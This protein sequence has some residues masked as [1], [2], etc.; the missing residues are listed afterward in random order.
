MPGQ[1]LGCEDSDLHPRRHPS[2]ARRTTRKAQA[3]GMSRSEFFTRAVARYL[4]ELDAE[5]ITEQIDL[6]RPPALT[7]KTIPV[8]T[9][10]PA[11]G[12]S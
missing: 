5:S 1:T 4:D 3:L 11:D 9:P 6:A 7:A 2:S 8:V 10:S 12:G